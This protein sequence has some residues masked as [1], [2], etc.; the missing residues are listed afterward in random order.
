MCCYCQ[1]RFPP[2]HHGNSQFFPHNVQQQ[3]QQVLQQHRKTQSNSGHSAP[4]SPRRHHPQSRRTMIMFA[5]PI[6]ARPIRTTRRFPIRAAPKQTVPIATRN[7]CVTGAARIRP[8]TPWAVP[9][10]VGAERPAMVVLTRTTTTTTRTHQTTITISPTTRRVTHTPIA[11][12]VVERVNCVTG[13]RTTMPV[14]NW[15]V[16]TVA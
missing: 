6:T 13:A 8:V 14:T 15:G 12:T 16:C 10:A 9:T 2:R 7:T 1:Q 3:R 5:H 11:S 4:K